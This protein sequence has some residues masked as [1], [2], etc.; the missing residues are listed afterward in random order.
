[1]GYVEAMSYDPELH[2][3][4][5]EAVLFFRRLFPTGFAGP[6]VLEVLAPEGWAQSALVRALHLT[7]EQWHAEALAL[8][9]S[10]ERFLKLNDRPACD[11][12][13]PAKLS[14]FAKGLMIL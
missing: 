11:V 2:Y 6:D 13:Q 5:E 7:L 10:M 4:A 14:V 8:H 3:D 9:E 12:E 1:M